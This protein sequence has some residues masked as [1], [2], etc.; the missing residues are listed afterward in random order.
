MEAGKDSGTG[1]CTRIQQEG[2]EA[3]CH[4]TGP[5]QQDFTRHCCAGAEF[6]HAWVLTQEGFA[7]QGKVAQ[8]KIKIWQMLE[9]GEDL[10]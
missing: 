5:L 1:H 9:A 3:S 7:G 10:N 6:L 8:A 4:K 2:N